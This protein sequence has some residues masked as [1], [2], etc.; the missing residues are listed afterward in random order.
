MPRDVGVVVVA[1]GRGVRAGGGVP[2]QFRDLA[3]VP[4]LLRALRPFTGHPE[5]AQVALVLPAESVQHLPEWLA[6]LRGEALAFVAG[7]AERSDSVRAGLDALRSECRTVLVHDGARPF[8]ER[9]LIDAVIAGA[10]AG[11][12]IVPAIPEGDTLKQ[13][14]A[15]GYTIERTVPRDGLWRAQTPQ[16]FPRDM[17]AAA[18]QRAPSTAPTD[19]AGMVEA[20]GGRVRIVPGSPRNIKVTTRADVE[21]AELLAAVPQ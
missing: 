1:A 17:L 15:D 2:K 18:Y 10:R 9:D 19:D 21:L 11:D 8:V 12:G 14:A 7:G 3:G 13:V 5:V 4:L 16:G 6:G 20:G